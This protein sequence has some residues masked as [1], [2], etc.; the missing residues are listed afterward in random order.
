MTIEDYR[1]YSAVA[2]TLFQ[3]MNGRI[4]TLNKYCELQIMMYDFATKN[5]GTINYPNYITIYIGNIVDSWHD[6]WKCVVNKNDYIGSCIAWAISHELHHADQLISMLQYN[7]NSNYKQQ[8]E[9]DVERAS[10]DW[11]KRHAKTINNMGAFKV[12]LNMIS[13][14]TLVPPRYCNYQKASVKEFYL[15]TIMNVIIRDANLFYRFKEFVDDDYVDAI[16]LSFGYEDKVIIKYGKEWLQENIPRFSYLAYNYAGT[17][18]RYGIK[19]TGQIRQNTD[20]TRISEI[21]FDFDNQMIDP[22]ITGKEY[23]ALEFP[24]IYE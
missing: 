6:E 18:D 19:V 21:R 4:N 15:Q 13:S 2:K 10:Y 7:V 11:V 16:I 14:P 24:F 1:W 23:N 9:N 3:Y 5:F 12:C 17:Y 8:V 22:L 20:E